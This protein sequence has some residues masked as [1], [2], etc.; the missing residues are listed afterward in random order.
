M[1][2]FC[3]VNE[4]EHANQREAAWLVTLVKLFVSCIKIATVRSGVEERTL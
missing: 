4:Q 1:R 2:V 3:H